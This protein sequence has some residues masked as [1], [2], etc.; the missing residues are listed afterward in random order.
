MAISLNR[1]GEVCGDAE[2]QEQQ[3]RDLVSRLLIQRQEGER[4]QGQ[5]ED[6]DFD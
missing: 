3:V 5:D 6:S 4:Q 2:H 1:H